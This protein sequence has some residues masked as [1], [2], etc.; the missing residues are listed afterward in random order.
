MADDLQ[1][2]ARVN[3]RSF[4]DAG[5]A[6]HAV[7]RMLGTGWTGASIRARG[8]FSNFMDSVAQE[9]AKKNGAPWPSGTTGN[10]I[11]S[12]SGGFQRAI[13]EGVQVKGTQLGDLRGYIVIPSPYGIHETG[14]RKTAGNKLLA[15]PLPAALDGKGNPLRMSPRDWGNTFVT[16]TQRGN[17]VIFQER[18]GSIVPLYVLKTEVTIPARLGV[19]KALEAGMPRLVERMLDTLV[20]GFKLRN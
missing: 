2:T 18:G 5:T 3:G 16:E 4:K 10:S 19:G 15:I 8:E 14:G 13:L 7:R 17:V 12:R 1:I 20:Q 9:I 11:S 6:L